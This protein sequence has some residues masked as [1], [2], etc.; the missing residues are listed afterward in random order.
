MLI[1]HIDHAKI[2][3]N[4]LAHKNIYRNQII[5]VINYIVDRFLFTALFAAF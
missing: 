3:M 1:N 4:L 5:S 2:Y